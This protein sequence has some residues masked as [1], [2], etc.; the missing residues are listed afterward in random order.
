M[1][2][3][4]Q[5]VS[6][7]NIPAS[8]YLSLASKAMK[9]I[10][11]N[12]VSI[13][14]TEIVADSPVSFGKNTWGETISIYA[15]NNTAE[16]TS[17]SKGTILFDWGRNRKN[18]HLVKDR[19]AELLEHMSPDERL[20]VE[21]T[22][23]V[24]WQQDEQPAT[25]GRPVVH[26][27][28]F[29]IFIPRGDFFITPIIIELNLLVFILMVVSGVNF[30]A[31]NTIDIIH[32]GGN[33]KPLVMAGEWWRLI[34]CMFLHFGIIHIAFN[35]YALFFIGV[36]LEPLLGRIK[37]ATAYLAAG[38]LSS[39][40]ST[41]WH[42]ENVVG[43]GASGAIFGLYGVF[44]ALLTTNIVDK[45]AR[46]ALLKSIG[47]FVGY[48]LF[49]GLT[50][51]EIDNSAH[52]GGLLSGL[53]IG[54]VLYLSFR[55][56]SE[57]KNKTISAV[58]ATAAI[59][60]TFLFVGINRND[61]I[62]FEKKFDA[63]VELQNK[64]LTV[65]TDSLQEI[66]HRLKDIAL[67]VWRTAKQTIDSTRSYKLDAKYALKRELAAQLI[68]LHVQQTQI[69]IKMAGATKEKDLVEYQ[70]QSSDLVKQMNVV[71]EE[72]NKP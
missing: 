71:A 11:W 32:W 70:E 13:T 53:V 49:Y 59:L 16:L 41:W 68:E 56:P 14:A 57:K 1:P 37:F 25:A 18:I 4:K 63:F 42:T 66:V 39:V 58:I 50:V 3:F 28:F 30:F 62:R 21:T 33:F 43:A 34:S 27:N 8:G 38:L 36:Y 17:K 40:A 29:H 2:Q 22:A 20:A 54:Y 64:A 9:E 61:N 26:K 69:I 47:I 23:T 24:E 7:E 51:K 35:M 15:L 60:T 55:E 45:Q 52:I 6:L 65:Q 46:Q 31:P 10:G 48:N 44:L 19:I 67:P 12:I 72:I 5:T